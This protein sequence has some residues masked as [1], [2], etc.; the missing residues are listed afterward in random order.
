MQG[1]NK[2]PFGIQTLTGKIVSVDDVPRG[3]KCDCHCPSCLGR[4]VARQGE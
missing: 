2:I 4:L 1:M 3:L